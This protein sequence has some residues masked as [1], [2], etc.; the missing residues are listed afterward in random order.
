MGLQVVE[1]ATKFTSDR[2]HGTV[3]IESDITQQFPM[4]IEELGS[5]DARN[6]AIGF[7]AAHGVPDPRINGQTPGAYP[8]N[9]DGLSLEMVKGEDGKPLP[10]QSPKMQPARYRI[11]I[12]ICR[13]LV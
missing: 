12:P 4:A 2:S 9:M 3:V 5:V 10:P 11:D 6:L 13:K 8:I 7:A 1:Q